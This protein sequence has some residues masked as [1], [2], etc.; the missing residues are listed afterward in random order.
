MELKVW[1]EGIQRIVCGVT[2]TTTCQDVVFAL[3]HAT[4]KS[5]RFT[6]IERWRNNERQLAPNEN[7][8]KLITKWGEYSSDV[9]FILQRSDNNKSAQ[10]LKNKPLNFNSPLNSPVSSLHSQSNSGSSGSPDKLKDS[11]KLSNFSV[12]NNILASENIGVVKGVPQ[13]R[14]LEV[15]ESLSNSPYSSPKK[16][17]YCGSDTSESP[18]HRVAPPYK[19]PP[20]PPP[21]RDPPPPPAYDRS[22]NMTQVVKKPIV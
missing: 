19:D 15:K 20:A 18:S 13:I 12:N 10:H 8:L 11:Y 22:R 16:S 6:L 17:S 5:G 1:V 4:G 21:Y 3:A 9:Q 14:P 7:P 2:E